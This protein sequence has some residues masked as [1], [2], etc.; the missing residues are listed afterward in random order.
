MEPV[1]RDAAN[2]TLLAA[3]G[4]GMAAPWDWLVSLAALAIVVRWLRARLPDLPGRTRSR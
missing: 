2:D 1:T 4:S 3:T